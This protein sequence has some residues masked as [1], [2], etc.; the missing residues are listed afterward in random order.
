MLGLIEEART[1][2]AEGRSL[3]TILRVLGPKGLVGR[4]GKPLSV[5]GLWKILTS[6][7]QRPNASLVPESLRPAAASE[8]ASAYSGPGTADA[9]SRSHSPGS[10]STA[11]QSF[12]TARDAA[13]YWR[14]FPSQWM[15]S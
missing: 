10:D 12:C 3:R 2:Q 8:P 14:R 1:M 4:N 6:N 7:T 15:M 9:K 11:T 13:T 5:S